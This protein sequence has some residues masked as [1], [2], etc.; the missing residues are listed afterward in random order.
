MEL[1]EAVVWDFERAA[2][3][4]EAP[5]EKEQE[6]QEQAL[7]V[8]G[9]CVIVMAV[10][11]TRGRLEGPILEK[12][13]GGAD[14]LTTSTTKDG[15]HKRGVHHGQPRFGGPSKQEARGGR[16]RYSLAGVVVMPPLDGTCHRY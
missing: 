5:L 6:E 12:S 13:P 8:V 7:V 4:A 1:L 9:L 3:F 2:R 16:R 10:V 15:E 11:V 14:E